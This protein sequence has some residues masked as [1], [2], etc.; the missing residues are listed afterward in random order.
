MRRVRIFFVEWN[1]ASQTKKTAAQA[2]HLRKYN[3]ECL[4]QGGV[5]LPRCESMN[6]MKEFLIA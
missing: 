5:F 2:M 3:F 4:S 1:G 6:E